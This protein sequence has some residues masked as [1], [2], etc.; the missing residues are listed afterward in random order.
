MAKTM[1]TL[2]SGFFTSFS[3]PFASSS[4]CAPFVF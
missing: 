2:P 1:V 4:S 3:S